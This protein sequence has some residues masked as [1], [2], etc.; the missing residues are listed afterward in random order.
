MAEERLPM[1]PRHD[2]KKSAFDEFKRF[3]V[4]SSTFGLSSHCCLSTR[5]SSC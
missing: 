4:I 1:L 2:L 5:A 3:V